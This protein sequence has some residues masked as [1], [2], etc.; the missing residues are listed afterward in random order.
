MFSLYLYF[1]L[2]NTFYAHFFAAVAACDNLSC[3]A[4]FLFYTLNMQHASA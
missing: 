2:T 4:R 3:L 1:L